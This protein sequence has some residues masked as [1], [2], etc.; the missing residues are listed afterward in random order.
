[1]SQKESTE[2]SLLAMFKEA[3]NSAFDQVLDNQELATALRTEKIFDDTIILQAMFSNLDNEID[4][5]GEEEDW[6]CAISSATHNLLQ[7][8]IDKSIEEAQPKRRI[9]YSNLLLYSPKEF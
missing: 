1:M 7:E 8:A 5:I 9:N 2:V 6:M 4:M 3:P